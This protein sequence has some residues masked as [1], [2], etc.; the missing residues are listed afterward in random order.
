MPTQSTS[1]SIRP[2]GRL[3]CCLVCRDNRKNVLSVSSCTCIPWPEG[4]DSIKTTSVLQAC[5]FACVCAYA[6]RHRGWFVC[7]FVYLF[8]INFYVALANLFIS[9]STTKWSTEHLLFI[10]WKQ[11]GFINLVWEPQVVAETFT[12]DDYY[13]KTIWKLTSTFFILTSLPIPK[14]IKK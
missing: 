1:F 13:N 11:R 9:L 14:L 4:A 8:E 5:I 3:K 10:L 2:T 6:L 12:T 7:L